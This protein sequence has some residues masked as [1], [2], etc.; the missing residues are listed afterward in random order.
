[1]IESIKGLGVPNVI[2]GK[3]SVETARQS[4]SK[5]ETRGTEDKV[6]IS[7]KAL[8][9]QEAEKAA[10]EVATALKGSSISLGLGPDFISGNAGSQA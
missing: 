1:M 4:E 8:N 10:K 3:G 2:T 9:Q 5:R 7:V 6:E